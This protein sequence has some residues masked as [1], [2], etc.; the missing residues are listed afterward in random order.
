[1]K[2]WIEFSIGDL[3]AVQ[4]S[5][6][7]LDE[8]GQISQPAC[9]ELWSLSAVSIRLIDTYLTAARLLI[10]LSFGFAPR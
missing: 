5:V 8:M 10:C 3:E 7:K 1:M 9:W 2:A 4:N 6:D